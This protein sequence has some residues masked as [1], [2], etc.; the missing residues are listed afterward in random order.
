M[1]DAARAACVSRVFLHSWRCYPNLIF[2]DHTLGLTDKKLEEA[3]IN[4]IH[5]VDRILQNHHDNGVK[6]KI[7]G[8][9]LHGYKNI[10]ASYLDRWLQIAVKSEIK[11]LN[12]MLNP[13]SDENY[14]SFPCSVLSDKAA[15]SSIESLFLVSCTFHSTSTLG[16]LKR[17]KSLDL[18]MVHITEEGLD[19][20]SQNLSR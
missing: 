15:A 3:E 11:Q 6:V 12:L 20:F 18:T 7:L 9:G 1:Q 4:L 2:N 14:Y 17:L 5:I 10:N 19:I 16:C 8:L 13:V